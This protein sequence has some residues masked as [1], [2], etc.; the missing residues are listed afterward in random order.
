M[1]L[2]LG[3]GEDGKDTG[4]F[5]LRCSVETCGAK[6]AFYFLCQID[7]SRENLPPGPGLIGTSDGPG[8]S[9]FPFA[10]TEQD[11]RCTR[12]RGCC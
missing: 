5:L 4:D 2:R 6:V 1:S 3:N 8:N 9:T 11:A 10:V 7:K 12:A